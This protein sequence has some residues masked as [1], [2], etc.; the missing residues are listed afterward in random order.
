MK[1]LHARLGTSLL[2][3]LVAVFLAIGLATSLIIRQGVEHY[4]VTRLDHD[5]ES[6]L[7][8]LS[9]APDGAMRLRAQRANPI[10]LRVYSGHYFAIQGPDS[11][12]HSRSLWQ[13]RLP[14]PEVRTGQSRT[15][16]V[17]GP[18]GAPLLMRA[19][20]FRRDGE[21]VVV[22]VAED[23]S[24][25]ETFIQRWQLL[26]TLGTLAALAG[27]LALQRW[28][29]RRGLRPLDD[30]REEIQGLEQGRL[31]ALTSAVPAETRPLVDA[32]N[33]LL[34]LLDERL[35]RSRKAA[36]NL[37][38]ALKAPLAE[39]QGLT[40]RDGS[41]L[42]E[43][44]RRDIRA[45]VARIHARVTRELRRARMMGNAAPGARFS[46]A[47][48]VPDLLA[49]LEAMHRERGVRVETWG[50]DA[51]PLNADREDMLE[52]LGNLLDNAFKWARARVVV[53]LD[54]SGPG[55]VMTVEDDGEGV[56]EEDLPRLRDRGRRLDES[57]DG[58]GLGLA[59]VHDVAEFYAAELEFARSRDLGGLRVTVRF[60]AG[61]L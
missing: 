12:L 19:H 32:L 16:R 48:D 9:V 42:P 1:S 2:A 8:A 23:V 21:P 53:T 33:R 44:L 30:I 52:L 56:P 45:Q 27:V 35:G 51:G 60:P 55:P 5:A 26:F 28:L 31:R 17:S 7:A 54:T 6:L 43:P 20:G 14:L 3:A 57:V 61:R 4:L 34:A 22:A 39:L 29:I 25:V 10:F 13:H 40:E 24:P 50:L 46:P 41:A 49:T 18:Q 58:H 36:G 37:A 59:I 11:R 38:H 47:E 15:L